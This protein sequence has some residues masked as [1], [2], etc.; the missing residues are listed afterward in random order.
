[1]KAWLAVLVACGA[2]A[3]RQGVVHECPAGGGAAS[4]CEDA[5]TNLKKLDCRPGKNQEECVARC[6]AA[7]ANVDTDVIGRVLSCYSNVDS[8]RDV[9][10]C[11]RACGDDDGPVPWNLSDAG[12]VEPDAGVDAGAQDASVDAGTDGG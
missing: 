2:L 12:P 1:M 9:D 10:G 11:S 5:C 7:S 3:C 6:E 4:T 8:C